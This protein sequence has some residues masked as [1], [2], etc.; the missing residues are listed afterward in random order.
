MGAYTKDEKLLMHF[1]QESLIGAAVTWYANLEPSRFYSWKALMVTFVRQY[2]Y[3][4]DMAPDRMQLQNMCKKGHESFKDYAQRW[5]DLAAQVAPPMTKKEIITMIVDMLLVFYYEKMVGYMPLSFADLVFAGE[6]IVVGPKRGKY[7]HTTLTNKKPRA[8][9]EDEK[10]EGTHA[11]TVVPTWSN[12]PPA[13]RCHYSANINPSY[14]VSPN[15]P[16][17]RSLNQPQSLSAAHPMPKTT[18][19]TNQNTN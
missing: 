1:F 10:E 13:Q 8:N 6:M 14:Y 3:N 16:Q 12:F 7:H 18:L 4:F 19:N 17:R 15:H 11:V 9:R 5:R 2:H